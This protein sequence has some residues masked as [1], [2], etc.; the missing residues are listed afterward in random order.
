MWLH[1]ELDMEGLKEYDCLFLSPDGGR[2]G[3]TGAQSGR[4]GFSL[5][6]Y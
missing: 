4:L 2:R 6:K 1:L 5:K 3:R